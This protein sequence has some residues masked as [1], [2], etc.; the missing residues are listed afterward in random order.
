MGHPFRDFAG[1]LKKCE[2]S[3]P[4]IELSTSGLK[5]FPPKRPITCAGCLREPL[6]DIANPRGTCPKRNSHPLRWPIGYPSPA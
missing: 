3:R 2:V 4:G 1:T 5:T 6:Q